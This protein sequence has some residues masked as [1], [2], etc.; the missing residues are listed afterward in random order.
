MLGYSLAI[1]A[2][3]LQVPLPKQTML[4]MDD[5]AETQRASLP[6]E[7][8]SGMVG[9]GQVMMDE[10]TSTASVQYCCDGCSTV[11]IL[12]R[13]WHCNVCPDFDLCEGCYEVMDADQLPPPHSRDHPMSAIPVEVDVAGGEG[14]EL[15][16]SSIDDMSDESLLQM[17][18]ELSL[19]ASAAP[20]LDTNDGTDVIRTVV[21]EEPKGVVMSASKSAVNSL[22]LQQLIT[23]IKG[24]MQ[25]SSGAQAVPVMQLFYR[26]A[27][28]DSGPLVDGAPGGGGLDLE[29]FIKLMLQELDLNAPLQVKTRSNLGEVSILV[30]MFFTLVLR[31]WHQPGS[32]HSQARP[33]ATSQDTS[34]SPSSTV[35]VSPAPHDLPG[36]SERGCQLDRACAA[37]RQQ[38]LV[39]YLFNIVQQLMHVFK[40][41]S[42]SVEVSST[43]ATTAACGALLS[44]RREFAS[45]SFTPF[46]SDSYA[47]AHRGDLFGDYHRLL[48]E[49]AFRLTYSLVHPEKS[50]KGAD[51]EQTMYRSAS[52]ADLKLEG[53]Q[54][55][56]CNYINNPHTT[57]IRKYARRLLL[58][59]C[60]TKGHYYNVRDAWQLSREV[61]RLYKLAHKSG[62]FQAPLPYE[63][64]VK[65]VKCLSVI[66]EVASARPR[67]WQ[68]YCSRHIDVVQ[69]LLKG[70]FSFGEESVVQTLKLLMLVFHTGNFSAMQVAISL[71]CLQ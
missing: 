64:S 65:L 47:K 71:A 36:G 66:A 51:K 24:W 45:G 6:S 60:G 34:A 33:I 49:S 22:L 29:L 27:S 12:R 58:H 40:T 44:V 67:N 62:G 56:L 31:N 19:Q 20:L 59:L 55:V 43:N 13:R 38:P 42:R 15:H 37:L 48:L 8:G 54:E 16:F 46:F 18:T 61:K 32:E 25:A 11:P 52:G 10:D 23:D 63:R 35:P 30:F 3:L 70:V 68:K 57:F 21:V 69:F 5:V 2:R 50:E 7:G 26:L 53:W 39:S 28:A 14:S 41:P 9:S 1:S 4:A 17:A